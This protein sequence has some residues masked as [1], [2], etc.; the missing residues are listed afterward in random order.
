MHIKWHL[1][2]LELC[3]VI[4]TTILIYNFRSQFT[5]VTSLFYCRSNYLHSYLF[6]E[7]LL[8]C[9]NAFFKFSLLCNLWTICIFE[10]NKIL[11]L[12]INSEVLQWKVVKRGIEK[13]T[14]GLTFVLPFLKYSDSSLKFSHF[15]FSVLV[16]VLFALMSVNF[17]SWERT[18][19]F[20]YHLN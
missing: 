1:R 8:R 16:A 18:V 15:C 12:L 3:Q 10:S 17:D 7:S 13:L 2:P 20:W 9:N 6:F 4:S 5:V 19:R 11:Y 14:S